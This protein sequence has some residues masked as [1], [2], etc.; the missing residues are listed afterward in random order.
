MEINASELWE[1]TLKFLKYRIKEMDITEMDYNTF[2]KNVEAG[3]FSNNILS[4]N[5][6]S[7]LIKDKMEKYK[8]DIEETVN[9]I[10][11][12]SD[13]KIKI[14]FSVRSKE[15]SPD[16]IYRIKEHRN[17][18]KTGLNVKN[19]LDNFIVGDN[20]KLAF[21]ACLAVVE[22]DVS[23]YNPLFIYGG[24]GL[25]KTHLMQ[26]VGNA[27]LE[28]SP[29]KR[30]FYCTTEEFINDYITAIREGRMKNFRDVFRTLDVL[31]LDD[32]QFFEKIFARGGGDTEEEFFHTFNKLQ[33]SGKQII[34]ISDRYPK[35]IKNLSKRL[36]SRFVAGLSVEIQY[37]SYETR[38]AI[39]EN[40]V[41]TKKIKIDNNILE[42]IAE[43]VSSNVRELEGILN[44]ITARANLLKERI[45]LQQVQ[46][47]ITSR[48]RS[49]QSKINA[50][51]I[52]E[53]IS[54]EYS[55]PISDMKARK[56]QQEIVNARQIAMFLLK[57]ILDLNLT[58]I[59]GLFGGKDH[60]T[61]ISSIR[62]IEG[63]I[64]ESTVF[65]K[66]LDRVRQKIVQ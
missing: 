51:K 1:K 40:I 20:S 33:E 13:E 12:V 47:E 28:K 24:S 22:S 54:E 15:L 50:E 18:M 64:E 17:K 4:L 58:T 3:D 60:S 26:A 61:V 41:E 8:K 57:D 42:Y 37:P 56:K 5:C 65:K 27:I 43:S 9:D 19:R 48:M 52:I 39:L 23:V 7:S 59:G 66:E 21:N 35:D 62:K 46:D 55:I 34:M 16:N 29:E 44:G 32:I 10:F 2:F 11:I 63:K 49:Q 6:N 14:S 31:L 25:G 45:T 36:E 38:K 53:V 30:V